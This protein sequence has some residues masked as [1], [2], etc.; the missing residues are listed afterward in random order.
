MTRPDNEGAIREFS[1]TEISLG[2]RDVKAAT[3]Q[4]GD[5]SRKIPAR[6]FVVITEADAE[7][8]AKIVERG[9]MAVFGVR[10]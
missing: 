1:P 3:H 5:S 2:T 10:P 6:P 4:Y 9:V 7:R 8:W